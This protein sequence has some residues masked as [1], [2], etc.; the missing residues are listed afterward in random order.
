M[1]LESDQRERKSSCSDAQGDSLVS[2]PPDDANFLNRRCFR[3]NH[4]NGVR[5]RGPESVITHLLSVKNAEAS[6]SELG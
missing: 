3:E 4:G 1:W 5:G 2:K 6:P